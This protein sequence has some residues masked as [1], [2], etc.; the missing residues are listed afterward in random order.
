VVGPKRLLKRGA[1]KPWAVLGAASCVAANG[2]LWLTLGCSGGV[3]AATAAEA[4]APPDARC[5]AAGD[6]RSSAAAAAPSDVGGLRA[7]DDTLDLLLVSRPRSAGGE[8][9]C[10]LS[11]GA[12]GTAF[13]GLLR[14]AR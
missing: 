2:P 11:C 12:C 6:P 10:A 9:D 1:G 13:A 7:G 5:V 14:T 3:D 8:A 4:A